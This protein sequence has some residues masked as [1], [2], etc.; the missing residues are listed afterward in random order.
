MLSDRY[1]PYSPF[2]AEPELAAL[3]QLLGDDA[4]FRLVREDLARRYPRT[5]TTSRP[6]TPVEVV[7]PLR[8]VKH[9]FAWSHKDTERFAADSLGLRRFCR[10]ALKPI[11][12]HTTLLRWAN[13]IQP[14]TM[15]ALLD[16][17]VAVA[18]A[19]RMADGRKLRLDGTVVETDVHH[20]SDSTLSA[21]ACACS[22]ASRAV[23]RRS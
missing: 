5:A 20:P 19:A 7:L 16:R 23:P 9:L 22:A 17:L 11:P 12:H 13:L 4:H 6:S 15:H 21:G 3:D 2:D 18:R 1:D 10:L 14:M 8:V